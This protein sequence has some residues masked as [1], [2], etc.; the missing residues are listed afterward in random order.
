MGWS[1]DLLSDFERQLFRCLGVFVGRVTLDAIAAVV[2]V[3]D[4]VRAD[5]PAAGDGV[6]R[7]GARTLRGLISHYASKPATAARRGFRS[8]GAC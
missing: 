1:Y 3:V 5:G 8:Y 7:D 4:G 2:S 6:A